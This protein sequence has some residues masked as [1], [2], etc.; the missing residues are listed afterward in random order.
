MHVLL[1]VRTAQLVL[2]FMC[3]TS[4]GST[5][6]G[7]VPSL[8]SVMAVLCKLSLSVVCNNALLD[9]SVVH[10]RE[11]SLQYTPAHRT[12]AHI[13]AY[14]SCPKQFARALRMHLRVF[15]IAKPLM[16]AL[17]FLQRVPHDSLGRNVTLFLHTLITLQPLVCSLSVTSVSGNTVSQLDITATKPSLLLRF[18]QSP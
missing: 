7:C 3:S 1:C 9:I 16:P 10:S 6:A 4:A 13:R 15:C 12:L 17:P 2:S 18:A 8:I 14:I 11:R 5:H